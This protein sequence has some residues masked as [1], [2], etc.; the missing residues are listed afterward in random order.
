[1]V[2]IFFAGCNLLF[3]G[4]GISSRPLRIF[5]NSSSVQLVG[6]FARETCS[7]S[8]TYYI[9]D[10]INRQW[11][12]FHSTPTF[13]IRIEERNRNRN[14]KRYNH[15]LEVGINTQVDY[16]YWKT[17]E[18][19][20]VEENGTCIHVKSFLL[21]QGWSPLTSWLI[22]RKI[23]LHLRKHPL[24]LALRRCGRITW[25]NVCDSATEITYWW[26]KI[27]PES[28]QTRWLVDRGSCFALAIVH[29][30]QT[31]DKRPQRSTVNVK[32]LLQNSQYLWNIVFSRRSI[33]VLLELVG[34]WTQH[35]TKINQK[36]QKIGQIYIWN[37][38]TTRFV[39]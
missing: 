1:M 22:C 25:R 2:L 26:H 20:V 21:L 28:S 5:G 4:S 35:F 6:T 12:E 8:T 37:P 3:K 27:C 16:H 10:E 36:T 34:R 17:T 13:F 7:A 38:M 32:N 18:T 15:F 14:R 29:E 33:W 39:M 9:T 31:K 11:V 23:K 19:L 24:L 30:W